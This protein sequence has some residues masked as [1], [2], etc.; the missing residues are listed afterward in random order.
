L[1]RFWTPGA[2]VVSFVLFGDVGSLVIVQDPN[3]DAAGM[4]L[5]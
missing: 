2:V 4:S 1:L 5:A 3:S